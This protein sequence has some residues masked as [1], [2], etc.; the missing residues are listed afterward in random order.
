MNHSLINTET[1]GANE[2]SCSLPC[3]TLQLWPLVTA[4]GFKSARQNMQMPVWEGVGAQQSVLTQAPLA[5]LGPGSLLV[6]STLS[7][8]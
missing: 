7:F 5:G 6:S 8:H 4:Y 1:R 3:S 2:L